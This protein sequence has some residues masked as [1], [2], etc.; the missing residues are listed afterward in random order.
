VPPSPGGHSSPLP[1]MPGDPSSA[2]APPVQRPSS[3]S[4][5][6]PASTPLLCVRRPHAQRPAAFLRTPPSSPVPAT[7]SPA[8]IPYAPLPCVGIFARAAPCHRASHLLIARADAPAGPPSSSFSRRRYRQHPLLGPAQ[9]PAR[10]DTPRRPPPSSPSLDLS[11]SR[12]SRPDPRCCDLSGSIRHHF[13]WIV[14][15]RLDPSLSWPSRPDLSFPLLFCRGRGHH[16]RRRRVRCCRPP[17]RGFLTPGRSKK[18]EGRHAGA[19]LLCRPA[20]R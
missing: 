8:W 20:D 6:F 17:W 12:P 7:S 19:L 9:A 13:G 5:L 4:T 11:L 16:D 15:S 1:A 3:V 18:Q 10:L 2:F 14:S